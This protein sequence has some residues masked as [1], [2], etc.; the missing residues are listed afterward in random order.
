MEPPVKLILKDIAYARSGDKGSSANIGI[1]AYDLKGYEFLIKYL[2]AE[3]VQ[4]YFKTLGVASTIRYEL[5]NLLALNFVLQGVLA[6]GGS[7]S[8]RIDAQGK[9]LGQALLEMELPHE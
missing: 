1:V 4:N 9:V 7:R 6:G 5:P 3:T 8:L 2:T